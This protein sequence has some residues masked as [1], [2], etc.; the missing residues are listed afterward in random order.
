MAVV[1]LW[2]CQNTVAKHYKCLTTGG[3]FP[4]EN[5]NADIKPRAPVCKY[6]DSMY[7]LDL[8][9]VQITPKSNSIRKSL[10]KILN[11]N[12]NKDR[13]KSVMGTN[14]LISW[15]VL[16][17]VWSPSAACGTHTHYDSL[18][19]GTPVLHVGIRSW[20]VPESHKLNNT[21]AK[22][23]VLVTYPVFKVFLCV[24]Y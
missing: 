24:R 7:L 21:I 18:R 16:P 17:I 23:N 14:I 4:Q 15:W 19:T 20:S 11:S 22:E 9:T 1:L 2:T 8:K 13:M 10:K 12:K 6:A 5:V 3:I